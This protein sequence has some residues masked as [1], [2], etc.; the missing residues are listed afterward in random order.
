MNTSYSRNICIDV[1]T[2]AQCRG[3]CPARRDVMVM[4]EQPLIN[5]VAML[6]DAPVANDV[7]AN[8]YWLDRLDAFI[9][10]AREQLIAAPDGC[11]SFD[12]DITAMSSTGDLRQPLRLDIHAEIEK[13]FN[14]HTLV[15][16]LAGYHCLAA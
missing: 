2:K 14:K 11:R 16:S 3:F 8:L 15:F 5:E 6:A 9:D 7:L 13:R 10:Q 4:M 12:F 1:T